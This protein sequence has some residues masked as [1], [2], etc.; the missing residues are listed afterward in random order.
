MTRAA[1][2]QRRSDRGV[3]GQQALE[4]DQD[5]HRLTGDL[6]VLERFGWTRAPFVV[7]EDGEPMWIGG[8]GLT[9]DEGGRRSPARSV[10]A[11]PSLRTSLRRGS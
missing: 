4:R 9:D 6:R 7:P 10:R 5:I 2:A 11:R 3:S 1:I 8:L